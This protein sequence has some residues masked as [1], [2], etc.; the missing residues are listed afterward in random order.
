MPRPLA[1]ALWIAVA[2]ALAASQ[3]DLAAG[4]PPVVHGIPD[5]SGS[6]RGPA[7]PERAE[8]GLVEIEL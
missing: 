7:E 8:S 2:L 3:P 5:G 6:R 1:N 4:G